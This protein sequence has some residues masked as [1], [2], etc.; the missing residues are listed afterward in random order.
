MFTSDED[1]KVPQFPIVAA[2]ER[3]SSC[4]Q[5]QIFRPSVTYEMLSLARRRPAAN[6]RR[7]N[8]ELYM[9]NVISDT[10]HCWKLWLWLAEA[11]DA[12]N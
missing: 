12:V 11:I 10:G 1:C 3:H 2:E 8:I 6:D 4:K 9:R 5:C 7:P